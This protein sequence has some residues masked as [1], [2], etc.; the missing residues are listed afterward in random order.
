MLLRM[1]EMR[2]QTPGRAAYRIHGLVM[3]LVVVMLTIT[4]MSF[5]CRTIGL[6]SFKL[7]KKRPRKHKNVL[8]IL[9]VKDALLRT[10]FFFLGS[11]F[12]IKNGVVN[13]I[14]NPKGVII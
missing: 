3:R 10:K 4:I 7:E 1:G 11:R 5:I 6:K 9:N 8:N 12:S 14:H 2:S 13:E